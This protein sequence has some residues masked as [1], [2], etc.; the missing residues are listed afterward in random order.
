MD[1]IKPKHN[2]FIIVFFIKNPA[3]SRYRYLDY[4]QEMISYSVSLI[5]QPFGV[6]L[7]T[8]IS[9]YCFVSA[10]AQP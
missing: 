10:C 8:K 9:R 4:G 7:T 2:A 6:G 1:K 3:L 5:K